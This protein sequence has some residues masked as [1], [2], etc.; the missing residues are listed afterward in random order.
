MF[1]GHFLKPAGQLNW[2]RNIGSPIICNA[3]HT[4]PKR[5][6]MKMLDIT[7]ASGQKLQNSEEQL[8]RRNPINSRLHLRTGPESS[9][10]SVGWVL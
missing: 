7:H 9:A 6:C 3:P 5:Y 1:K 10:R 8:T 4:P 2:P